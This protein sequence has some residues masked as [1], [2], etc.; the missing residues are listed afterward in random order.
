M[1]KKIICIV[2]LC[3]TLT[4]P[5]FA[6]SLSLGGGLLSPHS[7]DD[8]Y[9][10]DN[11]YSIVAMVDVNVYEK[12]YFD[13]DLGFMY[14]YH[15]YDNAYRP[16][17][18]GSRAESKDSEH[19][20]IFSVYTKPTLKIYDFRPYVLG[21]IGYDT[22]YTGGATYSIGAGL[23]YYLQENWAIGVSALYMESS[24]RTYRIKPIFSIRYTF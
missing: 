7:E 8:D 13:L 12:K 23:D 22:E 16:N 14:V 11:G 19:S 9:S 4:V 5:A 3:L 1:W 17:G 2:A 24:E 21:G 18:N 6:Q 20:N 15:S 10:L